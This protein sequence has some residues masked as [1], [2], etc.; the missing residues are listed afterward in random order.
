MTRSTTTTW[1]FA[2]PED[3]MAIAGM[4][5]SKTQELIGD[6]EFQPT[7]DITWIDT[8][9]EQVTRTWPSLEIAEQWVSFVT[10]LGATSA[11]VNPE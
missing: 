8:T 9:I 6:T 7:I 5:Q 11:V 3:A 4:I 2:E 10:G 1:N